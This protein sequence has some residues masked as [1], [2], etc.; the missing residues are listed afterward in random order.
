MLRAAFCWKYCGKCFDTASKLL[1]GWRCW[2]KVLTRKVWKC[3]PSLS[4]MKHWRHYCEKLKLLL[5]LLSIERLNVS[6]K[7]EYYIS[8]ILTLS[9]NF[10]MTYLRGMNKKTTTQVSPKKCSYYHLYQLCNLWG[11]K[12]WTYSCINVVCGQRKSLQ[13][14]ASDISNFC[15]INSPLPK[16][17]VVCKSSN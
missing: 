12:P 4:I 17:S 11:C 1:F 6:Y 9:W 7:S 13:L 8:L 15:S 16:T 5:L 2:I 10:W 14:I 3:T